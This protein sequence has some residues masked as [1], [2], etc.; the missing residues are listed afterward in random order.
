MKSLHCTSEFLGVTLTFQAA[1]SK[2][3]LPYF[4]A[5]VAPWIVF[6]GQR[7]VRALRRGASLKRHEASFYR[8]FSSFKLRVDVF[9]RILFDTIVSTFELRDILIV[10]DD[11]LC[12][13]WGQKIFGTGRFFD[14]VARPR[15]GFIW[16]HNWVVLSIVVPLFGANVALPFWI[17]L[18]R[19]KNGCEP[20]SFRTRHELVV[21]ALKT[22][23]SWTILPISLVADGAYNNASILIPL[24]ELGIPLVSRL[25][26]DARLRGNPPQRRRKQR[27]RRGKYGKALPSLTAMRRANRGWKRVKV[28][29][30]GKDVSM[31]IKSFVA[32][33]P[34]S[35]QQLLVVITRD[36]QRKRKGAV[37]STTVLTQTPEEVIEVFAR[38]WSIEQLFADAKQT[39][40]LDSA[41]VRSERSVLR[42]AT[43]AFG[44]VTMVRVWAYKTMRL[45]K[46][47][48]RSFAGQLSV[49]RE[50]IIANTIFRE[51]PNSK[52]SRRNAR[53]LAGLVLSKVP[54]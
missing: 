33:W 10:V 43:L 15:P 13:K 38:R 37:L 8:F 34:K 29:I 53:S 23:R 21:E 35:S 39:L 17:A 26:T 47:P 1:F 31:D 3:S 50:D 24:R 11:T 22:A 5:V 25:R 36:P 4:L 6:Q 48:H 44:F 40:G 14:H 52:G 46:Q 7:T 42:H 41:E 54:A 18:Y 9:R 16:G 2:R 19:P 12:P 27:G 20:G 30:Y 49:L 28:A 32:W 51:S 45:Q